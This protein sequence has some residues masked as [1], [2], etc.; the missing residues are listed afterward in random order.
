MK[1]YALIQHKKDLLDYLKGFTTDLSKFRY[2]DTELT[3]LKK[4]D[5]LLGITLHK[6]GYFPCFI[7]V[8][9]PYFKGIPIEELREILDPILAEGLWVFHNAKFDKLVLQYNGFVLPEVEFDT[10]LAIHIWNPDLD[11]NME[12]R[13]RL[14]LGIKKPTFAEIIGK[15]WDKINWY[16]DTKPSICKKTGDTLPPL[17][18]VKN[19]GKYGAWDGVAT[20]LLHRHYA[21]LVHDEYHTPYK[22]AKGKTV[23][24]ASDLSDILYRIEIP[25][26]EVLRDMKHTGVKIDKPRLYRMDD[27]IQGGLERAKKA[28]YKTA[29]C[30]F[31]VNSGDQKATVLYEKMG[32]PILARTKGGKPSTKG[33]TLEALAD[34]GHQIAKDL[35]AHSSIKTLHS[36][37]IATIPGLCDADGRLR[38]SFNSTGTRTGRFSSNGPNLQNQPN[39]DEFPVR[40]AFIADVGKLL[41]IGD[42]SQIE[43]RLFTHM[44]QDTALINIYKSHGDIYQGIANDLEITRKHAKL[45]V[46][47][48]SYGIGPDKLAGSLGITVKEAKQLINTGFYGEY[49]TF[50]KWK[51]WIENTAKRKGYVVN[52]FGRIRR[53]PNAKGYGAPFYKAMRQAVNTVVQGSAADMFKIGMIEL[54][55]VLKKEFNDQGKMLIQVH[56]ELILEAVDY[57]AH[58]VF[59][60]TV[61][62]M[63]NLLDL[64]VP[65]VFEGKVCHNWAQMKNDDDL[66]VLRSDIVKPLDTSFLL[67]NNLL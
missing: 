50:A 26:I 10:I 42:Y 22:D 45:V 48:V 38:C 61:D 28:I 40:E 53:L 41:V 16:V 43:P 35:L 31:N 63:E 7:F 67:A 39:N 23:R 57:L 51:R 24:D 2:L 56:D 29:K 18:T 32:L 52:M 34:Q 66:G 64:K 37:F 21:P 20:E 36:S 25:L 4:A 58:D 33:D 9:T 27:E 46:L 11:K 6:E 65:I 17:I 5:E 55:K 13:L 59:D 62:V 8:D 3:G 1:K 60:R 19:F 44:S 14:D 49:P 54:H 47:S 15:K 12:N 30:E